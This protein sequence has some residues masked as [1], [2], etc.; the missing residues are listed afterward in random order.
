MATVKH[1]AQEVSWRPVDSS[2]VEKIGWDKHQGMIVT[3]KSGAVYLYHGCSRQRAVACA[4]APSVGSYI[5]E[6]IKPH[7]DCTKIGD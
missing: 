4:Y 7:Y 5:N 1:P 3:F 2:N 6:V